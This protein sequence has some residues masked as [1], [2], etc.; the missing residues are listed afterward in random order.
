MKITTSQSII[1]FEVDNVLVAK[2]WKNGKQWECNKLANGE[3]SSAIGT[4]QSIID[5]CKA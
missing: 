2:A 4:K 5:Y 3:L 1:L